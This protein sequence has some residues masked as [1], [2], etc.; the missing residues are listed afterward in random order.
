VFDPL[1]SFVAV[2]V[3]PP[4]RPEPTGGAESLF[5]LVD[6][7]LLEVVVSVL[8]VRGAVAV[9]VVVADA[10]ADADLETERFLFLGGFLLGFVVV[11]FVVVDEPTALFE[12]VGWEVDPAVVVVL[13]LEETVVVVAVL[14]VVVVPG[15]PGV[16]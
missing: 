15:I 11:V 16:T 6:F 3:L 7:L 1:P 2:I 12:G 5:L 4:V 13:V 10:D 14:V 9:V 8:V